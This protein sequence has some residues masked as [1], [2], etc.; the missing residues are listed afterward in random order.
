MKSS[1]VK[2][3]HERDFNEK[4]KNYQ[5][6]IEYM[7][8]VRDFTVEFKKLVRQKIAEQAKQKQL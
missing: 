8:K 3:S 5:Q 4:F 1:N 2:Y 7:Q 6:V